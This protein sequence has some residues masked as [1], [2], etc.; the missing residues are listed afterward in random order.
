MGLSS[1]CSQILPK[2]CYNFTSSKQEL[3]R[4]NR[5]VQ[6]WAFYF[7]LLYWWAGLVWLIVIAPEGEWSGGLK[8]WVARQ[9][10]QCWRTQRCF[11]LQHWEKGQQ[12]PWYS[13]KKCFLLLQWKFCRRCTVL[14]Q[15]QKPVWQLLAKQ[16]T[17][18][19]WSIMSVTAFSQIPIPSSLIGR[20]S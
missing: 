18:V 9:R 12:A 7:C 10:R 14:R 2:Q 6:H 3:L 20:L 17:F 19:T 16:C 13:F 8:E 5:C 15:S 11:T 4:G 1:S